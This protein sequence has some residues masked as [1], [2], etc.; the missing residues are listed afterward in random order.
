MQNI[1]SYN[2]YTS[3]TDLIQLFKSELPFCTS[4]QQE[5]NRDPDTPEAYWIYTENDPDN[6][7]IGIDLTPCVLS[8]QEL[9]KFCYDHMEDYKKLYDHLER[10]DQWPELLFWEK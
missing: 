6:G 1:L 9:D 10:H 8:M 4:S 7:I 5:A 3:I 2:D